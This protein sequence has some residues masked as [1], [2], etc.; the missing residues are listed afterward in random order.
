MTQLKLGLMLLCV[1][2]LLNADVI[3]QVSLDTAALGGS[4]AGPFWLALQL[5][6]GSG[7]GD[8][9]NA[10]ILSG[11]D[12]GGGGPAGSPLLI[13]SASGDLSST[14]VLTDSAGIGYFAQGFTSGSHLQFQLDLTTNVDSGAIPDAF[15]LSVL[16]QTLTPIPTAAG[17]PLDMLAEI[18]IDSDHP[19]VHTFAGDTSRSPAAGGSPIGLAAPDISSVPEP[20]SCVLLA[21]ALAAAALRHRKRVNRC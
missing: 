6:D 4:S 16:D 2:L 17:F 20:G 12:F 8:G 9:N 11:F 19:A 14:V 15:I 3:Y 10:A 18:D 1:P 13:G 5:S 7:T 21:S